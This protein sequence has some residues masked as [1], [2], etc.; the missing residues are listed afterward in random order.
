[1]KRVTDRKKTLSGRVVYCTVCSWW[2]P[3]MSERLEAITGEVDAQVCVDHP[4]KGVEKPST[5]K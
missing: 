2:A 5:P 4:V 1:M 3:V